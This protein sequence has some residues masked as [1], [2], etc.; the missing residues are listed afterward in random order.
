MAAT[1]RLLSRRANPGLPGLWFVTDP[2]RTPD[3]VA[4]VAQ[5]PR[6]SAVIFRAFGATDAVELG[7]ALRQ[8]TRKAGVLLLAGAD[9]ALARRI[10]ADGIHLPE[11]LAHR[12]GQLRRARPGSLVTA[13]AHDA[14]AIRK[15]R[16]AGAQA[17][18]VSPVFPS[19]S[20]SAGRPLGVL[21]FQAL[22]RGAGVPVVALGGINS[23]TARRLK[24]TCAAGLAAVEGVTAP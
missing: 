9:S 14:A 3:P 17:V 8:A 15:A 7:R 6:G 23:R 4:T 12:A 11:R 20:P 18:L 24:G 19:R 1:A 13:A 16:R 2:A 10:G 5:L 22:A 21:R